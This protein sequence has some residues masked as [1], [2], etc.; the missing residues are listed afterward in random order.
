MLSLAHSV[1]R[2]LQESEL[3]LANE[4]AL[5]EGWN[6]GCA[7][8]RIFNEV[9]PG[10]LMVLDIEGVPSGVISAVRFG[11]G[12]GFI[13]F[14][15]LAPERRHSRNAWLLVRATIDRMG[16]DLFGSETIFPLVRTYERYGVKPFYHTHSYQGIAPI[17]PP[18]WRADVAPAEHTDIEELADYDAENTGVDRRRFFRAW[19][20]LPHSLVLVARSG[21]RLRGFGVARACHEGVRIGPLQAEDPATAEALFDG[22]SG[23][24]PGQSIEID[25][26][27]PNPDAGRLAMAKGLLRTSSTARLY[28]GEPPR[29][30]L[31]RVYGIMSYALG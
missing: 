16:K 17:T 12:R 29:A 25:C 7:D 8:A 14:F 9:D 5:H 27:E 6:P 15:V 23:L 22:L 19:A 20:S 13:G 24:A 28:K 10:S 1:V 30:R 31:E 3:P 2:P 21:G 18:R 26:S 4:W 11:D